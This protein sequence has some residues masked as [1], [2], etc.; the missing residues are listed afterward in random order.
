MPR[1]G[2]DYVRTVS[3]DNP[4]RGLLLAFREALGRV[5]HRRERRR[6]RTSTRSPTK[7]P[8][9]AACCTSTNRRRCA[10]SAIRLMKVSQNLIAETL[11]ARIGLTSDVP[12]VDPLAAASG[13]YERTLATWGVPVEDVILAD[14]SGPVA[15]RLPRPS[16]R[17]SRCCATWRRPAPRRRVRGDAAD[18]GRRRHAR[19]PAA[20]H[21]RRGP[22]PRQDRQHGERPRAGRLRDDDRGRAPRLRHRRQQLQ[23][24]R[25]RRSTS[26]PIA[27]STRW[28]AKDRGCCSSGSG[29]DRARQAAGDRRARGVEDGVGRRIEPAALRQVGTP[30]ALAAEAADQRPEQRRGVQ[31]DVAAAGDHRDRRARVARRGPRPGRAARRW[32]RPAP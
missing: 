11:R 13:A 10:R 16:M 31:G 17:W 15:L 4:T 20:R 7:P 14:G 28:S 22:R 27:P 26:S 21:A 6:R 19:A 8:G 1:S 23:G 3:T 25:D 29:A 30:A 18:P 5:R 12:D 24:A 2:R 9:R 32:R